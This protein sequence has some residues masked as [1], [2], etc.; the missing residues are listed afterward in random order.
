MDVTHF[1]SKIYMTMKNFCT[2]FRAGGGGYWCGMWKITVFR[3]PQGHLKINRLPTTDYQWTNEL[4]TYFRM[5]TLFC[6]GIARMVLSRQKWL[7]SN[8]YW[9]DFLVFRKKDLYLI[10]TQKLTFIKSGGFHEIWQIS[11]GPVDFVQ[12]SW[13]LVDFR[14]N[15]ADFRWNPADFI[16]ISG[17]ISGFRTDFVKSAG[18]QV[19]NPPDFERPIARNGKPYVFCGFQGDSASHSW[20][21]S[22]LTWTFTEKIKDF[23]CVPQI[24]IPTH[25]VSLGEGGNISEN[26]RWA[27]VLF[28]YTRSKKLLL[29]QGLLLRVWFGP[30]KHSSSLN[31]WAE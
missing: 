23:L 24:K 17:E 5:P 8:T 31:P 15:L 7:N 13:N 6:A 25:N 9:L 10:I 19:W 26:V 16:R 20:V 11:G 18:F 30:T 21:T 22:L 3:H 12:I 27:F 14:W 2:K 28:L 29:W 1:F 4:W